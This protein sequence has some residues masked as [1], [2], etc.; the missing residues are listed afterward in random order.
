MR[1]IF[2][3]VIILIIF[4]IM[5]IESK[6]DY[7]YLLKDD[8]YNVYRLQINNLSTKNIINYIDKLD[9][10]SIYPSVNPIYREQIGDIVYQVKSDDIK[11]EVDNFKNNYLKIIKK[12]NY[13]DYN[14]LYVNGI[15]IKA[16]DVYMNSHEMYDFLNSNEASV[17]DKTN[18]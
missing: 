7:S 5:S 1:K 11:T 15:N 2:V 8:S 12:N 14:Y 16:I 18:Y 4:S 13:S 10:V 6:N 17:V 9:I 3:I